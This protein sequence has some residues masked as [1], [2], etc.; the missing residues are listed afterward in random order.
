MAQF[1]A[2]TF[3]SKISLMSTQTGSRRQSWRQSGSRAGSGGKG[4]VRRRKIITAAI[5]GTF[6]LAALG[7]IIY[8]RNIRVQYT[9]VATLLTASPTKTGAPEQDFA[10]LPLRFGSE[11]LV[12]LTAEN[13]EY[14]QVAA[15][16][17]SF[18]DTKNLKLAIDE[19]LRLLKRED[20][21]ILW[22]RAKGAEFN[23][24]AYLLNGNYSLPTAG[25][26]LINPAGAIPFNT[27][28]EAAAKWTGPVLILLDWGNQLCDPRAGVLDNQ[29]LSLAVQDLKSAPPNI[30]C[31]VSH[32]QGEMSLDSLATQ[33]T[34]FGR[35]CAEGIVGPRRLP[36]TAESMFY[37]HDANKLLIGD[38]AEYVIRRV[39][40]DSAQL[41]KPWLIQGQSGWLT[42]DRQNWLAK[43]RVPLA[44]LRGKQR[45]LGWSRVANRSRGVSSRKIGV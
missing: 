40:T 3:I 30:F 33:Q 1:F 39:R 43:T 9:R 13:T 28:V 26:E 12:P 45:L 25:E 31:L 23:G 35:A 37:V 42:D 18:D 10:W 17:P 21:F 14:F 36:A 38:L 15:L 27:I 6:V 7:L 44:E 22:I 8:Q 11:S 19:Q 32:Q 29:F 2:T 5:L 16:T 20:A 34:L 24:R 41:Q 4:S